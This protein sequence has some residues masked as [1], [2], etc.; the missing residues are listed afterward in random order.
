MAH[1]GT[2]LVALNGYERNHLVSH[3]VGSG[4]VEE[5]HRLLWLSD[6]TPD[7]T[8]VNAW[9]VARESTGELAAYLDDIRLA[10]A[11][12]EREIHRQLAAGAPATALVTFHRY[13]LVTATVNSSADNIA[14]GLL[15]AAVDGG[16][17]P[18]A[19]A[20]AYARRVPEAPSRAEALAAVLRAGVP[21]FDAL[22]EEAV[23]TVRAV[24]HHLHRTRAAAAV[25]R[26]LD[27]DRRAALLA[28]T[29]DLVGAVTDEHWRATDLIALAPALSPDEVPEAWA[30]AE[31][32]ASP[33]TVA[34]VLAAL[35]DRMPD[36]FVAA[37]LA[38]TPDIDEQARAFASRPVA[39]S[40]DGRELL[41]ALW[42]GVDGWRIRV[43]A[44]LAAPISPSLLQCALPVV[45]AIEDPVTRSWTLSSL[46][47]HLSGD[48]QRE[49]VAAL[50]ALAE[51]RPDDPEVVAAVAGI[52]AHLSTDERNRAF[53][54][55]AGA[56]TSL[57]GLRT[58]AILAAR[59][60]E[61][62][63]EQVFTDLT[64]IIVE[65]AD[66][67]DFAAAVLDEV[68]PYVPAPYGALL[69]GAARRLR[70][71]AASARGLRAVVPLAAADERD[72]LLRAALAAAY[73]ITDENRRAEELEALAPFLPPELTVE[74]E[75]AAHHFNTDLLRYRVQTALWPH[76]PRGTR[77]RDFVDSF[78]DQASA[79]PSPASVDILRAA[80]LT[81]VLPAP[82]VVDLLGSTASFEDPDER[83]AALTALLPH[84]VAANVSPPAALV[85]DVIRY[86]LTITDPGRRA[87]TLGRLAR[88]LPES[89][90][91]PLW[92]M[93]VADAGTVAGSA[94]P[95]EDEGTRR[96]VLVTVAAAAPGDVCEA[97][98]ATTRR[99]PTD[100]DR[101]RWMPDHIAGPGQ[102]ATTLSPSWGERAAVLAALADRCPV[103]GLAR[104]ITAAE[105]V[106]DVYPQ[107]VALT[108]LS[109]LLPP[110]SASS[111]DNDVLRLVGAGED[112]HA[113]AYLLPSLVKDGQRVSAVDVLAEVVRIRDASLR[114][115]ALADLAPHVDEATRAKI[116]AEIGS[117]P[118]RGWRAYAHARSG[119]PLSD[120]TLAETSRHLW[121]IHG[122]I[123]Q[124]SALEA[125]APR[126]PDPLM[127]EAV[128]RALALPDPRSAMF[129]VQHLAVGMSD[130]VLERT[131]RDAAASGDEAHL[132]GVTAA[133]A[134]RL[135]AR[136]LGPAVE[137][138]IDAPEDAREDARRGLRDLAPRLAGDVRRRALT[139]AAATAPPAWRAEA[140]VALVPG[141]SEPDLTSWYQRA[142]EATTALPADWNRDEILS[143]LLA[144][145]PPDL[146]RDGVAAAATIGNPLKRFL[147]VAR[148][149]TVLPDS[150]RRAVLDGLWRDVGDLDLSMRGWVLSTVDP[151]L[152]PDRRGPARHIM[153]DAARA[154]AADHDREFAVTRCVDADPATLDGDVALGLAAVAQSIGDPSH[155][156]PALAACAPAL[157]RHATAL[158]EPVWEAVRT[159]SPDRRRAEVLGDLAATAP[160]LATLGGEGFAAALAAAIL[161][162]VRWWP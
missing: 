116:A 39:A 122:D 59:I 93:A 26:A 119:L 49:Q 24:A 85:E 29:L 92:T 124:P 65:G 7:G 136:L 60:H 73:A 139:R 51:E 47:P 71:P 14:P 145:V 156:H 146:H 74:A 128:A 83:V 40:L 110:D 67:E 161:D 68:A 148:L 112:E 91:R 160:V 13:T 99:L 61:P 11:V 98:A 150:E 55:A 126:L 17:W 8:P 102:F 12:A 20:L 6:Q 31:G 37:V 33:D 41:D 23:A 135:P 22:A 81:P 88:W 16:V 57:V 43:L 1:A 115:T 28:E 89:L 70:A 87:I 78:A 107:A 100:A 2:S 141:L 162:V 154:V 76:L 79:G 134:A 82:V 101:S 32:I 77:G 58:R 3:L 64:R 159:R 95:D 144:V 80:M 158:A 143:T 44:R 105:Y 155:R 9:Y 19:Q 127:R 138:L 113:R 153:L 121:D 157:A 34:P 10:S 54:T 142:F 53:V 151:Y 132:V 94:N 63:R 133:L 103:I 30:L 52:E 5:L 56:A 48:A 45:H 46:V 72:D 120:D 104:L 86:A 123:R 4:L 149:A 114:A 21:G 42:C 140:M 152:P 108:A 90:N 130:A 96:R 147:A 36:P 106:G 25:L 50:L 35:I 125:L 137:V 84:A 109:A 38:Q 118:D 66:D 75:A 27:D 97:L 69:I 18:S 131:Y 111:L 129:V 62:M 117:L 15:S